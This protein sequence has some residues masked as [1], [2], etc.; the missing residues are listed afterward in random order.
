MKYVFKAF[1][2]SYYFYIKYIWF[3]YYNVITQNYLFIILINYIFI[4]YIFITIKILFQ[5]IWKN[6]NVNK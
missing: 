6:K 3:I 2:S 5:I 4:F 1:L